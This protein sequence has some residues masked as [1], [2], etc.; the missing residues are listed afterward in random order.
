MTA[1]H[2]PIVVHLLGAALAS[3]LAAYWLLLLLRNPAAPA[4]PVSGPAIAIRDPDPRLAARLFGDLNGAPPAIA[5]NVQLN[6]V[7]LAG[8]ASSAVLAVDGKPARAVFLGQE[9]ASGLRLVDVRANG[10]TLEADGAR[11]DYTVPPLTV[12]RGSVPGAPFRREGNTLTAPSLDPVQAR[13][14]G[15]AG[16]GGRFA[17]AAPAQPSAVLQP[18]QQRGEEPGRGGQLGG[19]GGA[20]GPAGG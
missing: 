18:P 20:P 10:V 3:A 19:P 1:R 5:R 2:S 16:A 13:A 14:A 12:A 17:G 11:T 15:S 8:P 4:V 7:Y 9:A 6:G